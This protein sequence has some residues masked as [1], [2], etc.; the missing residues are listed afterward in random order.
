MDTCYI[1]ARHTDKTVVA[2]CP[3][4]AAGCM[5]VDME[6]AVPASADFVVDIDYDDLANTAHIAADHFRMAAVADMDDL[7]V[8][9][10][11]VDSFDAA[12]AALAETDA[13]FE[14]IPLSALLTVLAVPH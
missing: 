9:V 6:D 12:V 13:H 2:D 4:M 8:A 3:D 7:P 1:A 5:E 11:V 10:V 14:K